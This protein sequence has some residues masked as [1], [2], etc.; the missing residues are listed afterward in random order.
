MEKIET[1]T[2]PVLEESQ[3][4]SCSQPVCNIV[5]FVG[6][7]DMVLCVEPI[8][9]ANYFAVKPLVLTLITF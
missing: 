3:G 6:L 5:C 2:N 7:P 1:G 8:T 9:K 4:Y